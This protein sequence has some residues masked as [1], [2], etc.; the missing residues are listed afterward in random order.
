LEKPR[1]RKLLGLC[2]YDSG[3][4]NFY[5]TK[6]PIRTPDDLKGMKIRVQNSPVAIRMIEAFG[7]SATPIAF[8]ELYTALAQ[9]TV[10][11]AENNVPS[12]VTSRHFEVSKY[13]SLNAHTRVPDM[14][15]ISTIV[16]DTLSPEE[17]GWLQQAADESAVFQRKLW[18]ET[19]AHDLKQVRDTGVE[20]IETDNEAFARKAEPMYKD[21][22]GTPASALLERIRAVK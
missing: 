22:E 10:D 15:L 8:G 21:F 19:T 2:Y 1:D 17:K 6:K 20:V 5:S 3:S 14:V 7:G 4:R 16:W 12:F 18:A 13:F 9:G 11:G